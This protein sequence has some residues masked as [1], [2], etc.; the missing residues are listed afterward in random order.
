MIWHTF[1]V[2]F[3]AV[4]LKLFDFNVY[5]AIKIIKTLVMLK[6]RS[7]DFLNFLSVIDKTLLSRDEK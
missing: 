7:L 6:I 3:V 1:C 4:V 5:K 2:Y